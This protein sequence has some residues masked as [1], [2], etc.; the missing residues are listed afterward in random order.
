VSGKRLQV[1]ISRHKRWHTSTQALCKLV[2][3]AGSREW[4]PLDPDHKRCIGF[5]TIASS[6]ADRNLFPR[7]KFSSAGLEQIQ[8]LCKYLLKAT[9]GGKAYG[10]GAARGK[11]ACSAA[12]GVAR[13][14]TRH[15]LDWIVV[16][17]LDRD[18]VRGASVG[19]ANLG[20]NP[21]GSTERQRQ[22]EGNP[23]G[24]HFEEDGGC[25]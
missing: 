12:P 10:N 20:R 8:T 5:H 25:F 2:R 4:A 14:W 13:A 24:S 19:R 11:L 16:K 21:P 18:V 23:V 7:R 15:A 1:A 22:E 9:Q 17:R 3:S 6:N